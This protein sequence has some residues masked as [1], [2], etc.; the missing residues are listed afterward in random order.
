MSGTTTNQRL[1]DWVSEW[2]AVMQPADI[3]WC[4]GSADEYERL[5]QEL[6]DS[7]TFTKLDEAK[8]PNSY[9][10]HSDPGDVARVE[11]R[12][13][14]CSTT[15]DEAGPNNNW[16]DPAEMRA[17]MTRLYSGSMKGRTMYVVPF[18]MGPLGSPIAHIGVQL[19]DS[20]YVAVNM[21]IMTRMGQGAL[22]VLGD[23]QWVPC[24]HSV[25]APLENGAADVPWPC[26]ADNKYIVH[27]PETREIW[28]YGSGYGGNAL[29]G[30][31]CFALRI[32]SVMARDDGWLAEHMLILKLTNPDGESKYI[33][34]AFP[35][36]CG[37][38]NL[39]MLVPT[40]PGWKAETIGD[41]IC[42]MKFGEDGRLW[43]INP[44]AG[45]FGV[46]PG[47]SYKTNS[48]AMDTLWGN[49]VYTNTAL[50]DDGDIWWEDMTDTPPARATDWKGNAWNPEVETPAAHPNARFTAPAA[51]CPSI[52]P[53]WEDPAGVPIS[54]I[55]FGGRR[56]T[57]VPLVTEANDW[58]HGVFLGSI[59]ASETT[60]A[61][62]GAVGNL[63]F[64]PM[65]MLPFCGYNY[66]DYFAHWLGM[67]K[68]TD[69]DKLPKIFFVNWFR[70]DDDGRF[71]W[72]GFGENSRVL[73]WIFERVD[74]TADAV[75]TPIGKLPTKDALDTDG[76]E[77]DEADLDTILS[78]DTEGWT[79]ALPQ[80]REHFAQ[81]G[82]RLPAAL[83][84]EVD[85][86]EAKLADA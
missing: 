42:W 57:T 14:I 40:I 75:D 7:G 86:L 84:V 35:S 31:K 9:W 53:E 80:I 56:R 15:E 43:A 32:A 22:D 3:Y 29:L 20:A 78:V 38:T 37:K 74:G 16:R 73:K 28:S 8:R 69:P 12:T 24:L 67:E 81:F 60:A 64:D 85:S 4:D 5:C 33:A 77:I 59:M 76:L 27:F 50:T 79:A 48:N 21:R 30:K 41:D 62:Q 52:A 45:F 1:K 65:A 39:A 19:T 17:E 49:C 70:R 55:L 68:A 34:G 2:A 71:L 54:A 63:R 6:V 10:A 25:G 72:P 47:T 26:D 66:A 58:E 51:Q 23:G 18:S 36:A 61:Q 44:E 46:A 13:Y 83:N 82:D 11:D